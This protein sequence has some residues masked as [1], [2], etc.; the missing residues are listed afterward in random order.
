MIM[1]KIRL[2][3]EG[4]K[5]KAIYK[6]IVSEN[7]NKRNGKRLLTIGLYDPIEKYCKFNKFLLIKYLNFGAYPTNTVRHL[8]KKALN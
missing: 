3:R 2:K 5:K 7:L 6:I 8:I 4:R 1:L